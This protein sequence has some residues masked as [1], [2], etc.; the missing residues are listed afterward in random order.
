MTKPELMLRRIVIISLVLNLCSP[1]AVLAQAG[2]TDPVPRWPGRLPSELNDQY[3]FLDP[4]KDEIVVVLPGRLTGEPG[5]PPQIVR[6]PLRNRIAPELTSSVSR[7]QSGSYDYT[8]ALQNGRGAIET[9][10]TWSLVAPCEDATFQFTHQRWRCVR[11][12]TAIAKQLELPAVQ[13]L[14]CYAT[15]FAD[16]PL[17]P[18]AVATSFRIVSAYKPGLTTASASHFPPFEARSNWPDVVLSQLSKLGD[19]AWSD[20]HMVT[21][22]PRFAVDTPLSVIASD[23]H[24]GVDQLIRTRRLDIR[25]EFVSELQSIVSQIASTGRPQ[26]PPAAKPA[27]ELEREILQAALISLEVR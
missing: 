11:S 1:R 3:V 12:R 5:A 8:Y 15:C 22:A 23:F 7:N 18:A 2:D 26:A 27:A 19:P 25:S 20:K 4:S 10:T 17:R 13:A 14:G 21:I 6:V 9:V 16:T 24:D